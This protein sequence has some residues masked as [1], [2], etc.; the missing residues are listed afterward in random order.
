MADDKVFGDNAADHS[1]GLLNHLALA[2]V[3][4]RA[5]G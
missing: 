1:N 5:G 2:C 4:W 3:A